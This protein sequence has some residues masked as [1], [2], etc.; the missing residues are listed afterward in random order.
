[1]DEQNQGGRRERERWVRKER[2]RRRGKRRGRVFKRKMRQG[3][4]AG[5]T[6]I[7]SSSAGGMVVVVL[8][9]AMKR[10]SERSKGRLR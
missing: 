6:S 1:M 4:L 9:V 8:A 2:W 10:T 7:R 5:L 3:R